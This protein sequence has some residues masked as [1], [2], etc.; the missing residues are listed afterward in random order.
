MLKVQKSQS[1]EQKKEAI[2]RYRETHLD[3]WK[4][5]NKLIQRKCRAY[6]SQAKILRDILIA[7]FEN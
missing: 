6:K 5:Y 3:E 1:Y 4:N 7:F 2:Y